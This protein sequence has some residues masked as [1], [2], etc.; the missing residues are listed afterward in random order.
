MDSRV[1]LK[2]N[3]SFLEILRSCFQKKEKVSLLVDENGV[4]RKEGFIKSIHEDAPLISI[5]LSDGSRI[6][7]KNIVAVNGVFRP[8]YGEC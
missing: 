7:L 5:E 4:E 2:V 8:E 6:V 1:T 3:E